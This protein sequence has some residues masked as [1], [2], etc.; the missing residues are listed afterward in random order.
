MVI[1]PPQHA[2]HPQRITR[3]PLRAP[4]VH[5]WCSSCPEV[6]LAI[7]RKA[8][9]MLC[10]ISAV[11]GKSDSAHDAYNGSGGER[12]RLAWTLSPTL[13]HGTTQGGAR[14]GPGSLAVTTARAGQTARPRAW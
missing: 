9:A 12:R 5:H 3:H 10:G 13:A 4:F 6:A 7:L 2:M 8:L 1:M 11:V 14:S